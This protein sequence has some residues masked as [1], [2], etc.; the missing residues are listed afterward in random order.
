[1]VQAKPEKSAPQKSPNAFRTISEAA[2]EL[3]LPQHVLRFWE[4]KFPQIKPMKRAGGR[5]FYRREDLDLLQTIKYLLHDEGYTIKGVQKIMR[6]NNGNIPDTDIAS[7]SSGTSNSINQEAQ[8][9]SDALPSLSEIKEGILAA[10]NDLEV[11]G[12]TLRS[13]QKSS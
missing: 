8:A 10:I 7:K 13:V 9:I 11:V 1:M 5:R 6:Q 2:R 3:D 4:S 12:D